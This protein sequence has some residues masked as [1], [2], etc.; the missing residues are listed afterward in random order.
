MRRRSTRGSSLVAAVA[1]G[2]LGAWPA[3]TTGQVVHEDTVDA[4]AVKVAVHAFHGALAA[5]D[6]ARALDLLHPD[7]RV[8]EGGHAETLSQYRSGHLAADMEFSAAVEREVLDEQVFGG[9]GRAVYLS[10]YRMA[11]TFLGEEVEARGTETIVLLRTPDGWRIR[12][13]HWSSR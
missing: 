5:G 12:H 3:A 4:T 9:G 6:S 11:G 2:F 10:E 1:L 7:V 13:I 8:F